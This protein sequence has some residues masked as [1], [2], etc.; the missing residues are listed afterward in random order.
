MLVMTKS[1]PYCLAPVR[2]ATSVRTRVEGEKRWEKRGHRTFT[3][4]KYLPHLSFASEEPLATPLPPH[5]V[6]TPSATMSVPEPSDTSMN[7]V[8]LESLFETAASLRDR[9]LKLA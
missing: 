3:F 4:M 5:S 6:A 1:A 8:C 7:A 2:S 9:L